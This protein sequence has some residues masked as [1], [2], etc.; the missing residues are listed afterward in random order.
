MGHQ[1]RS[2]GRRPKKYVW[3]GPQWGENC[4]ITNPVSFVSLRVTL[5]YPVVYYFIVF[6]LPSQLGGLD[7]GSSFHL[8]LPI[9]IAPTPQFKNSTTE[10]VNPNYT[11]GDQEHNHCMRGRGLQMQ[12]APLITWSSYTPTLEGGSG[13]HYRSL[14]D[15]IHLDTKANI[16]H[17]VWVPSFPNVQSL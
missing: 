11:S 10:H 15:N 4:K 16:P 5:P 8:A 13:W 1:S 7:K 17:N 6:C 14:G 12:W 3:N 9:T 2:P